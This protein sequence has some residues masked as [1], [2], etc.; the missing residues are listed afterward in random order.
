MKKSR[1]TETQ[2]IKVLS[3]QEQGKTVAGVV[4]DWEVCAPAGG[5]HS[6]D[7]GLKDGEVLDDLDPSLY[8]VSYHLSEE[9]AIKAVFPISKD[10]HLEGFGEQLIFVRIHRKS[11]PDCFTV[12]SFSIIPNQIPEMGMKEAYFLCT[13]SSFIVGATEGYDTYTWKDNN[14]FLIGT[15][16]TQTIMTP[17]KYSLT[18][19]YSLSE[20]MCS[21]TFSFTVYE[22]ESL[23][24]FT[25]TVK[26]E[27]LLSDKVKITVNL[28]VK[29]DFI[30][31]LDGE[32][33]QKGNSFIVLPGGYTVYVSDAL[34][35]KTVTKQFLAVKYPN[36]FFA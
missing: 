28:P 8:R 30:Y 32:N 7:L 27:D 24:N 34:K 35:C 2:I 5:L 12:G 15:D 26:D 6:F 3:G 19:T 20:V 10:Y 23:E 16:Q 1:F 9:N 4:G 17:G 36:F 18:A 21:Q 29:G 31:S 25:I 14:G 11:L 22:Q 13:G 33:Y